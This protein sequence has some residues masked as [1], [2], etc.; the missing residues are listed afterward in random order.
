MAKC[1]YPYAVE[2][3][4]Y[5]NQDTKYVTVP[6][7]KC[8]ECLKRRVAS[9]SHRLEMESL[10]WPAQYFLTL[11]YSQDHVPITDNGF[12]T[13]EK[14]HPQLF[15]KRLRKSAGK[16]RY[17]MCGEYGTNTKRPHYH[18]ILFANSPHATDEIIA[19]WPYGDV[20]FGNVEPASIR[21]T[22]QYYDKGVWQKSHHRDDRLPEYSVMSKG[23]GQNFLT[24][25]M[26]NHLL[27][28]PD[29]GYIYD[30]EGRKISI[31]RYYKKKLYDYVGNDRTVA[32]HPSIL[33]HR[34][35][36]L[37]KKQ[38]HHE[39]IAEI[40]EKEPEIEDTPARNEARRMAILNYRKTKRKT[41]K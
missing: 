7:G 23:I 18:A 34:D 10:R 20:H 33:V 27:E 35:D 28:N 41:R 4:I 9:W 40:M 39:K 12:L 8:P 38:V 22:V 16:L 36:M 25:K 13:L 30:N 24:P 5:H 6:C 11:T 2:R 15:F 19:A 17:Y 14:R 31:P 37:D 3:K 21:Y 1:M 32:N 29:K 26:V